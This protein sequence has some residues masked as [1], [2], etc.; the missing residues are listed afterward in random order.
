M[1]PI[2]YEQC[3]PWHFSPRK[4]EKSVFTFLHFQLLDAIENGGTSLCRAGTPIF[5]NGALFSLVFS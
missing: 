4:S 1:A 3:R 5:R 2:P